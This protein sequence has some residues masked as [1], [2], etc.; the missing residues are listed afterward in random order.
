M[1]RRELLVGAGTLATP[2]LA[3]CLGDGGSS[4]P[5]SGTETGTETTGTSATVTS[6][7][8][9]T[10]TTTA[11]PSAATRT[12]TATQTSTT[13]TETAEPTTRPATPTAT[14][15]DTPGSTTSTESTA[16][17]RSTT[18]SD[19]RAI[20]DRTINVGDRTCG[21]PVSEGT[22]GF[23]AKRVVATG[24]ITGSDSCATAII[25]E[26]AYDRA[27]DRLRLVVAT[28][29]ERESGTVCSQ[30]LT[31]I[32][33]EATVTFATDA[34]ETV[35]LVHRGATDESRVTTATA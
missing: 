14:A 4:D 25:G 1:N 33:Y 32:D 17:A 21:N 29:F 10:T 7:T 3:G 15:T 24:T 27:R 11:Q 9:T 20:T 2:L 18:G 28:E 6:T 8:T 34:P 5:G 26:A 30:C 19:R 16:S 22:I 13:A 31:E 12:P 35:V 23:E